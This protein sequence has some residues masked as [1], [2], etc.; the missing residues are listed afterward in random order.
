MV[1]SMGC[2]S[3]SRVAA[4]KAQIVK[5][6]GF[7]EAAETA[8]LS[9]LTNSEHE[10]YRFDSGDGSQRAK[11]RSPDKIRIEIEALEATRNRLQRKLNGTSNVNMNLRRVRGCQN[12]R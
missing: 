8:Y 6:D 9:A 2:L 1:V 7:I 5:L 11:R 12:G 3:A 4:I 10:E